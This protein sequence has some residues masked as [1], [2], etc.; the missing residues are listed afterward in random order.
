MAQN[1]RNP[2]DPGRSDFGRDRSS[3]RGERW[4]RYQTG[5]DRDRYETGNER[6]YAAD[7]DEDS[8]ERGYEG[9]RSYSA[10]GYPEE[11]GY[12]RDYGRERQGG[13]G[14]YGSGQHGQG[15]QGEQ[16]GRS[17]SRYGGSDPS[18]GSDRWS[19]S[20]GSSQGSPYSRGVFSGQR[21]QGYADVG[22][23][24]SEEQQSGPDYYG[25][26]SHYGG[27]YG[28]AAGTR[29]TSEGW[30][31]ASQYGQGGWSEQGAD[32]L[33]ESGGERGYGWQRSSH[34]LG[35]QSF[36][37]GGRQQSPGSFRGRG[38]RGYARSDERLKE[39]ICER[40]TDDPS[41]DASEITIEV[42]QQVVKLTGTV[43]DRRTKY[44]VEELVERFGGVKDID[45]QLRVQ[46]SGSRSG[47]QGQQAGSTTGSTSGRSGNEGGTSATSSSATSTKRS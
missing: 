20:T 3:G 2:Q 19:G 28:T 37:A 44:E 8:S 29:A 25:T 33:P 26:G 46:S 9:E 1:Y 34:E 17:R 39:M 16:F 4:E 23:P 5:A 31:G 14:Q 7:W 32:W 35:S 36:G 43:D 40:L 45:N 21:S 12:R 22:R 13:H 27:G 38:P 18:R 30:S 10:G 11:F 15:Q 24:W 47:G 41:I 6:R 42:T